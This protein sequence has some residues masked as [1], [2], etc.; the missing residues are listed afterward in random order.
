MRQSASSIQDVG[1]AKEGIRLLK[2]K[3][4]AHAI[5]TLGSQ[6]SV[7]DMD[8]EVLYEPARKVKAVD[9]TAAGDTFTAGIV[10]SLLEGKKM[11]EAIR[12]ATNASSITVTRMG[13]QTSIPSREEVENV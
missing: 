5:V 13:A 9:S 1:D 2:E 10:V 4:I 12:F 8:D 6:G 3:G 11:D 7:F